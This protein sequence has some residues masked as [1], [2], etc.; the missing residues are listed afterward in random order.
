M[1][2]SLV[3]LLK[4]KLEDNASGKGMKW[5]LAQVTIEPRAEA[6]HAGR[7]TTNTKWLDMKSIKSI[8]PMGGPSIGS[9]WIGVNIVSPGSVGNY[10]S[11]SLI[12]IYET[13]TTN[14]GTAKCDDSNGNSGTLTSI[15][16]IIGE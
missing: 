8:Y 9:M 5:Q 12:R 6:L 10:A 15:M 2:V 13:N 11:F 4:G 7:P 16:L 1:T 14:N 3:P